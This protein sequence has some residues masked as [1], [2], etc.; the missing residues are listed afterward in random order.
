MAAAPALAAPGDGTTSTG[1][2]ATTP[3][4]VVFYG[5]RGASVTALQ[6]RLGVAADGIFGPATLGAVKAFQRANGL[7][8]DG[9]VGPLTWAKIDGTVTS[10]P[11][12]S[13]PST[14][15]TTT[16][17]RST[18]PSTPAPS[19]TSTACSTTST[20]LR[21]GYSG[22]LV[23]V[24]QARVG[25]VVDGWFG[26]L[27]KAKVLEFQRANGLYAD[28]IVGP[29]TWAKLGCTGPSAPAPA[30]STPT[31]PA[32]TTP[33]VP[34][35]PA[36]TTPAPT[37]SGSGTPST[38]TGTAAQ[39]IA[40]AKSFTGTP[41]LW[42]GSTAAGFDCSGLTSYVFK[43][44]GYYMPRTAAQ[45]QAY[46]QP[47]SNPQPGDLLFYGAPAYH[48]SIYLG[49]GMMIDS[50]HPG[51]TVGARKIYGTPSGYARVIQ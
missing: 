50:P 33:S 13:T 15:T 48:V 49:D 2:T 32:P 14:P 8:A 1:S 25:L 9:I 29:L 24:L 41:Y 11:T 31:T 16:P 7:Y 19:T 22:Q 18:T 20:T 23:K 12:T 40:L 4:P 45:Q 30:S 38:T 36:S 3:R 46:F 43:Q 34:S 5:S 39:V 21:L 17:P 27:T 10:T 26:P 37:T 6:S 42:G 51:S 28:G 44:F 35:T 47:V